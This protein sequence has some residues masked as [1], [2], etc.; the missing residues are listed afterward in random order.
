MYALGSQVWDRLSGLLAAVL[1]MYAPY[2]LMDAFVRGAHSE[3]VEFLWFH[4]IALGLFKGR[5]GARGEW[6][7]VGALAVAGLMVTHTLIAL[8]AMLFFPAT[9]TVAFAYLVAFG[10]I[11]ITLALKQGARYAALGGL[12]LLVAS[13]F[14]LPIL[15]ESRFVQLAYFLQGDY[16]GDV[17]GPSD[18][19]GHQAIPGS[20]TEVGIVALLCSTIALGVSLQSPMDRARRGLL[21]TSF[22][23]AVGNLYIAT[24]F[25]GWLWSM[26]P[27]CRN[28]RATRMRAHASAATP[29]QWPSDVEARL[30]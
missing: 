27:W 29:R 8:I 7:L 25:S 9:F 4:L 23:A 11:P 14:W 20:T 17:L 30:R 16:P 26:I 2:H 19:L 28:P 10:P 18:L 21:L 22:N 5:V 3:L 6:T 1:Y 12:A 24:R 13:F 15:A